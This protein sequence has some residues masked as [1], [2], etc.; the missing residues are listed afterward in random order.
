[1]TPDD[2]QPVAPDEWFTVTTVLGDLAVTMRGSAVAGIRLNARGARPAASEPERRVASEL[3]GYARGERTSFSFAVASEGTA[4]D[5]KVWDA[6]LRIPYGATQTYG[7]IAKALGVPGGARA[8]GHANGRNPIPIVIPCHRVVAAGGK[9]GGYGGGL[10]L[11]RRLL[12]LEER[13]RGLRSVLSGVLLLFTVMAATACTDPERPV[14]DLPFSDVDTTG[15]TIEFLPPNA[16]T[17]LPV[18]SLIT[19]QLRVRDRSVIRQVSAAVQGITAFGFPAQFPEDTTF[20]VQYQIQA[21]TGAVGLLLF[22]VAAVDEL[23][24]RSTANRT[25]R[26][27]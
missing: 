14:F 12:A 3:Q 16:D 10:P 7:A 20:S 21:P 13:V 27:E 25:Y 22:T 8:V 24:Y 6:V 4:F 11:K 19:V 18:G 15:P 1:M 9:L 23:D 5:R 2:R 26:L 17:V